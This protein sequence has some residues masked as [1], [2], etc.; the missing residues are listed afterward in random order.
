MNCFMQSLIKNGLKATTMDGIAS[1]LQMSKRSLYELFGN[2]EDL[3]KEAHHYFHQINKDRL[4]EIFKNSSNVMEAIIKCFLY[5]RDMMSKLSTEFIRDV[6]LYINQ[7]QIDPKALQNAHYQNLYE[8]LQKGVEEGYFR[9]DI[10]LLVQCR[11]FVLQMGALK[12]IEELFPK[13]ITLVDAYDSISIGFLR[14]IATNK[15]LLEIEKYLPSL[16]SK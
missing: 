1:S 3:F 8:V 2:K 7:S 11:M 13:D 14:G 10:N 12:H 5:N 15:G 16:K 9:N 4:G 6:E